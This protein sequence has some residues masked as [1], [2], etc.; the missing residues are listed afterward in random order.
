MKW[1]K[2]SRRNGREISIHRY[3]NYLVATVAIWTL[4]STSSAYGQ[5]YQWSTFAGPDGGIGYADGTN[6]RFYSPSGTAVDHDGNVYVADQKNEVIRK[7]APN[8]DTS[9][10][11][12]T[13]RIS[14]R[15]DG[16][17]AAASFDY[18][19]SLTMDS[20]GNLYV[21]DNCNN[22]IRKITPT[23]DVSTFAGQP[24]A[25]G[26]TDGTGTNA[27]FSGPKGI[28]S[29]T[30]GTLYVT[31]ALNHAVRKITS[32]GVVSTLAGGSS[33]GSTDGTKSAA[34]FNYPA[35]IAIDTN[36]NLYVADSLNHTIRK[37]TSAGVVS[38]IAGSP[39]VTGS[40]DGV[41][42]AARFNR[43]I[44]IVVDR[45]G[46][47]WVSDFGNHTIRKIAPNGTVTTV[48]GM[49]GKSGHNDSPWGQALFNNPCGLSIDDHYNIYVADQG[50]HSI[51]Q[52]TSS[53]EVLTLAGAPASPGSTDG[54]GTSARFNAPATM[55]IDDNGNLYLAERGNYAIRKITPEG[56]VTTLAGSANTSGHADGSGAAARFNY[57]YG[58]AVDLN[59]NVYASEY[60]SHTI[61]KIT[62]SGHVRTLAGSPGLSGSVDGVGSAARFKNPTYL[63]ID[64]RGN[65]FVTD[66]S[67]LTLRKITP[68]GEVSIV[69]RASLPCDG[70]GAEI[71]KPISFTPPNYVGIN[72]SGIAIDYLNNFYV[73][74]PGSNSVYLLTPARTFLTVN[75]SYYN[76][77]WN[78][79][80]TD[81]SGNVYVIDSANKGIRKISPSG[82]Y[83]F[84]TDANGKQM[85]FYAPTGIAV[86]KDG[87]IYVAENSNHRITV[88]IPI[89][90][91]AETGAPTAKIYPSHTEKTFVAFDCLINPHGRSTTAQIEYG[92]TTNYD[93]TTS[94]ALSPS[95]GLMTQ[96]IQAKLQGLQPGTTYHYRL[97][98]SNDKGQTATSDQTFT[99]TSPFIVMTY[100]G[101]PQTRASND[102]VGQAARFSNPTGLARDKAGNLYVADTSNHTIRK[103]TPD[104]TVST[105]AGTAGSYGTT[106]GVGPAARFY[107]PN[108]LTVDSNGNVFVCDTYNCTIRK[109]TPDGTVS[110]VAGM[111]GSMGSEDGDRTVARFKRPLGIAIASNGNLYVADGASRS[112]RMITPA[113]D[114]STFAGN[115]EQQ[116]LVDGTGTEA[117]FSEPNSITIDNSGNLYVTDS[118]YPSVRKISP[119]RVVTTLAGNGD[120][121]SQDGIGSA[122]QFRE[123]SG[124]ALDADGN[125]YVTDT[126]NNTIRKITPDG[127]VST[128]AGRSTNT[129]N[130]DGWL[131]EATFRAPSGIIVDE[132]GTLFISDSYSAI[133]E[134]SKVCSLT[135]TTSS[136]E[137]GTVSNGGVFLSNTSQ[138]VTATSDSLHTF[139]NW[140]DN[141]VIVSTSSTYSLPLNSDHNLV[142]NFTLKP[143]YQ[144]WNSQ[145]ASGLNDIDLSLPAATP[146]ND[147][148]PNV[149]KYL[150]HIDPSAVLGDADKGALP[151]MNVIEK[152][153]KEYLTLQH[154]KNPA[155]SDLNVEVQVSTDLK[156]WQTVTPDNMQTVGIDPQ[157]GDPIIQYQVDTLGAEQ[158]FIR[159]N[160]T[161][162]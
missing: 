57:I 125:L 85:F 25:T 88:G 33:A 150:C 5:S 93:H 56:L 115:P 28:I 39:G 110:T 44:G 118:F 99:T 8:G 41:G 87:K 62:P 48:T 10:F 21:A 38:T 7:I 84:L 108:G 55:T 45:N 47:L 63:A 97:A 68:V 9:T 147:G 34:K 103:I 92:V 124:I 17:A 156:N 119:D 98:T 104:G 12:G 51:R 32:T 100:A 31:E 76:S 139:T 111:S 129:G 105:F 138:T 58:L 144:W 149:M 36:H 6:A 16:A 136:S 134:I 15:T 148:V 154:R 160:V 89:A 66:A 54:L 4:A 18:P 27:R 13:P 126:W 135:V 59:G 145:V 153:A 42:S 141:G 137:G 19:E 82:A 70:I 131:S 35:G 112:I 90:P 158:K 37:V 23:G 60:L 49:A 53:G 81:H 43:P 22:T 73:V 52:I 132:N 159:L 162:P 101:S 67:N 113:G 24:G 127:T 26:S 133:R 107:G 75:Y 130:T 122:A 79:C 102:G 114:V 80:A 128:F 120:A 83:S 46:N 91:I 117:Q 95:D 146:K 78:Q 155:A 3:W 64:N 71:W 20:D 61:R 116:G 50:N 69:Q 1:E 143:F 11:A 121:G 142:A 2:C 29:D 96:C 109:I 40:T 161:A 72:N 65:L 86:S 152:D 157:T 77:F 106:D 14:G 30:D 74:S 94:V 151:V 123:P 140:T